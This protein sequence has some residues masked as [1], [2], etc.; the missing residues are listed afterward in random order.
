VP[1]RGKVYP[2]SISALPRAQTVT[3]GDVMFVLGLLVLAAAVVGSVELILAN[4]QPLTV[5]M[6][7]WTWHVDAFWLAVI[8]AVLVTAAWLALGV[9]RVA[10]VHT[11]RLRRERL[12]L[13]AENKRLAAK[14]RPVEE[15]AARPVVGT[16][17]TA[18]SYPAAPVTPANQAASVPSVPQ[19]TAAATPS[20]VRR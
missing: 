18:Q 7:N 2:T 3:G 19:T 14:V 13:A 15:K 11:M 5:H 8:G 6:W 17:R 16:N 20:E 1:S 10:F 9:M 4:Q 12:E